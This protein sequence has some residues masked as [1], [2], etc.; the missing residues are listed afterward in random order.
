[1]KQLNQ[2]QDEAAAR[3]EAYSKLSPQQKLDSLDRRLGAGVGAARERTK[4][5][6]QL[7]K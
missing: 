2:L 6:K 7:E 1:M 4:L 5:E 3:K